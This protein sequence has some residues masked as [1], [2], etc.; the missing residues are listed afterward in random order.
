MLLA[1]PYRGYR[2]LCIFQRWSVDFDLVTLKGGKV[3]GSNLPTNMKFPTWITLKQVS[4]EYQAVALEIVKGIGEVIGMDT[5]NDQVQDPRFCIALDSSKGWEP[6]V[7]VTNETT[8]TTK[9]ILIDYNYL[10]IR[11]KFCLDTQHCVKDCPERPNA[12]RSRD[13]QSR[14]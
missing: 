7:Q 5:S 8:K 12:R 6:L 4:K 9:T 2:G 3:S 10:P 14:R 1:T 11:C 13:Q